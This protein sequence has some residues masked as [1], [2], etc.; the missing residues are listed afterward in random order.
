MPKRSLLPDHVERYLFEESARESPL[1]KRLR[2]ET[3]GMPGSQM[4]IGP[5]QGAL[6]ALLVRL[7]GARRTLEVGVYTGYSSL[8]VATALPDDGRVIACDIN[9]EW[10]SVARRYWQEAGVAHKIEL[11]LGPAVAT[12]QQLV[13]DGLSNAFD[14]AFLDADKTEYDAYYEASL[15][16][17]RPGGLIAIDNVLWGGAVADPAEN[18]P[19]T[20]AIRA[21]NAKIA[22]DPRVESC[23]L[24]VGDGVTLARRR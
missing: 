17:V 6:L 4:Q 21:L 14:F 7:I 18:D 24:S 5:D 13:R 23:L 2:A 1:Q 22:D 9:E 3:A 19:D 10:T 15:R 12:L 8:T 16:L 20:V 11:R